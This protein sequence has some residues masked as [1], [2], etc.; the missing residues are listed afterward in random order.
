M[1]Q[2]KRVLI[3]H[4]MFVLQVK[5]VLKFLFPVCKDNSKRSMVFINDGDY[6]LFRHFVSKTGD[7]GR[8]DGVT[9]VGPQFTLMCEL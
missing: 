3:L 8:V 5:S 9:E 4:S 7:T 1:L 6:I 2:A